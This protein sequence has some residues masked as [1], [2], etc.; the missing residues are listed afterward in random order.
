[1]LDRLLALELARGRERTSYHAA[2][3][4]DLDLILYGDLRLNE[5]GLV[6]PHPHFRE[7]EFVLA[8][9]AEIASDWIDPVRGVS[10]GELLRQEK[11]GL[12]R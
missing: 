8:P 3:T 9:L 2:R 5:P 7:R 4:L 6:V 12:P 1:M 10:V 11:T